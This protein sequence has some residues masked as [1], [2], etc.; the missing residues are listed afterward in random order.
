MGTT[1]PRRVA[2]PTLTAELAAL[3]RWRD[4]KIQSILDHVL[5]RDEHGPQFRFQAIAVFML[6]IWITAALVEHPVL[7]TSATLEGLPGWAAFVVGPI[8]VVAAALF[9]LDVLRHLVV[10][11]LMLL[12]GLRTGAKYLADLFELDDT[13]LALSYLTSAIFG[14]GYS[15]IEIKDGAVTEDSRETA[16]YRIGGPGY[17]KIH[18]GNAALFER[19]G[20]ETIIYRAAPKAFVHGFEHLREVVDLREKVRKYA[21]LLVYTKDGIP[22]KVTDVQVTF[23]LWS[24]GQTRSKDDPYPFDDTALRRVVYGKAIGAGFRSVAWTEA[25]AGMA[26]AAITRYFGNRLLKDIIAQK[27]KVGVASS[28]HQ[29]A[30]E[31][32]AVM[33]TEPM[34]GAGAPADARRPLAQSFHDRKAIEEFAEAGV[35]LVWIGVG[36]IETPEDVEQELINAWQAD[37]AA[38]LKSGRFNADEIRRSARAQVIEKLLGSLNEWWGRAAPPLPV[39]GG[40]RSSFDADRKA[41]GLGRSWSL[42]DTSENQFL[43]REMLRV[44]SNRLQE[45]YDA[46]KG[47][48][49]QL[50]E[51]TREALDYIRKLSSPMMLGAEPARTDKSGETPPELREMGAASSAEAAPKPPG[52]PAG[53]IPPEAHLAEAESGDQATAAPRETGEPAALPFAEGDL[54]WWAALGQ[55]V[56]LAKIVWADSRPRSVVLERVDDQALPPSP[57]ANI[58]QANIRMDAFQR[59]LDTGELVKQN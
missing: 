18:L 14:I 39:F 15:T 25:I 37:A 30:I 55:T 51:K 35:E 21:D 40:R 27:N 17:V 36:T 38:R 4:Q 41:E 12:L 46:L 31:S 50:P 52:P 47:H 6:L 26:G 32:G 43:A 56:R 22:V 24:G 10:P 48:T 29:E 54:Y 44:Y 49:A 23:R 58:R 3:R 9:H 33:S 20:G 45:V 8:I 2:R 34:P 13:Q 28:S 59:L 42:M 53:D 16:P 11:L 57:Q 1:P 5:A 19:P 7:D